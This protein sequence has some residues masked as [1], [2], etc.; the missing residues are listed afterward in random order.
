MIAWRLKP[1]A[2]T[3]TA[4]AMPVR[5]SNA[6]IAHTDQVCEEMQRLIEALPSLRLE[7]Y[8]ET[9]KTSARSHNWGKAHPVMQVTL[10]GVTPPS[11]ELLAKSTRNGKHSRRF[12]R[13]ELA[14]AL[15]MIGAGE[16]DLV[17]CRCCPSWKNSDG[18]ALDAR[19]EDC[20]SGASATAWG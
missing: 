19:G 13:H 15:A 11:S 4:G 3:M 6:G 14:S 12:F 18:I 17:T 20:G 7:P 16:S 8:Y 10:Q 9:L 2:M 1:L 5:P